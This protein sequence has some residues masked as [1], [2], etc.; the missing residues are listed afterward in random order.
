MGKTLINVASSIKMHSRKAL[1]SFSSAPAASMDTKGIAPY[2]ASVNPIGHC[3]RQR[4]AESVMSLAPI[5]DLSQGHTT[6]SP[7][8]LQPGCCTQ[9]PRRQV[10][11]LANS[12]ARR[13]VSTS[14]VMLTPHLR[15][16]NCLASSSRPSLTIS[17]AIRVHQP[18]VSSLKDGVN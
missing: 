15:Y 1:S 2:G 17:D 4:L 7:V 8:F 14:A 13:G 11:T 5:S 3:L 10:L 9:R 6:L 12:T 16:S 18:K